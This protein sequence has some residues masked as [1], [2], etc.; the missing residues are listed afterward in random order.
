MD[1]PSAIFQ[2]ASRT[3][4]ARWKTM[5]PQEK[6]TYERSAEEEMRMYRARVSQ[7]E[8]RMV[9][10]ARQK[11]FERQK[12]LA[13]QEE[14][15]EQEKSTSDANTENTESKARDSNAA[16]GGGVNQPAAHAK[17]DAMSD[18]LPSL[19]W[20]SAALQG[21]LLPQH[22]LQGHVGLDAFPAHQVPLYVGENA[23]SALLAR[24]LQNQALST[25]GIQ[26]VVSP[27]V[28]VTYPAQVGP[29]F[30]P[31]TALGSTHLP[32]FQAT[33][34]EWLQRENILERQFA[35]ARAANAPV[36]MTIFPPGVGMN[37]QLVAPPP[38]PPPPQQD[39]PRHSP[40][41]S[42]RS[43]S[44]APRYAPPTSYYPP[45]T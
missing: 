33:I 45:P 36:A 22:G 39:R 1:D 35:L 12:S 5:D 32:A 21:M 23:Q 27:T 15:K 44:P 13:R 37:Q 8:S 24:L 18:A 38:P 25:N 4:A 34:L 11:S 16:N 2:A 7:Y 42:S 41:S 10:E 29:S 43:S 40:A 20:G 30:V 17:V 9:E 26:G 28:Y 19:S 3:L 6:A 31:T 14:Q